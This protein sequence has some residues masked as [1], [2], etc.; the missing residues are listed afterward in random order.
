MTLTE[1]MVYVTERDRISSQPDP[2]NRLYQL[3]PHTRSVGS[4]WEPEFPLILGAWDFSSD[5]D[6]RQRFHLHLQHAGQHGALDAVARFV[7]QLTESDWHHWGEWR[8]WWLQPTVCGEGDHPGI[9]Y[10]VA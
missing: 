6:K 4:V 5:Y 2:W 8:Q 9:S 3:L 7:L 10:Y 1:L